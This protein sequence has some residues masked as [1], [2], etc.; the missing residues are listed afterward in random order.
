MTSPAVTVIVPTRNRCD[1]LRVTLETCR[2]QDYDNLQILVSDNSSDDA[3][4]EVVRAVADPRVRYIKTPRRVSMSENWEFALSHVDAGYVL[5]VGDDDALLPNAIRDITAI[6]VEADCEAIAWKESK[7]YW[8]SAGGGA[9]NTLRLSLRTGWRVE[10]ARAALA[11]VVAYKRHYTA[12]PSLYWGMLSREAMRR[13]TDSSGRFFKS[14]NP[15]VYSALA[16]TMAIDRFVYSER[17]YRINGMSKHST[18]MSFAAVDKSAK[19]PR[20]MFLNEGNIPFHEDLVL[21]PSS[22][23]YVAEA[24]LQARDHVPGGQAFPPLVIEHVLE[25]MMRAASTDHDV[26]YAQVVAGVH[27]ISRRAG[28]P[29]QAAAIVARH[30]HIGVPPDEFTLGLSLAQM[31]IKIACGDFA[32]KD[33][34]GAALLAYTLVRL[35][36]ANYLS[37][38]AITKRAFNDVKSRLLRSVGTLRKN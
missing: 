12:L 37:P 9:P 26:A 21:V 11:D 6:V 17:P 23:V 16:T 24:Y 34:H 31:S 3:T 32:V 35:F 13:A 33:V 5:V 18:G 36:E 22:P 30:P 15:D 14:L 28:K 4:A 8:P 19:S 27:E 38:T 29:E 20:E 2:M 7:Y 1:T 10:N 25:Q